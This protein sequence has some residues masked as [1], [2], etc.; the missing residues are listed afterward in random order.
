M[1]LA[2][3]GSVVQ[4]TLVLWLLGILMLL[5]LVGN[6]EQQ[7]TLAH[8]TFPLLDNRFR[9]DHGIDEVTLVVYR[10]SGSAPI[11]LVRPDGS[12]LYAHRHPDNTKWLVTNDFDL[13]TIKTPVPGPW[14]IVGSLDKRNKMRI[15]SNMQLAVDPFPT[16]IFQGERL[17]VTARLMNH[18][19]RLAVDAFY[20][21]TKLSLI[22]STRGINISVDDILSAGKKL[23]EFR[24]DGTGLDEVPRDGVFT[25]ALSFDVIPGNFRLF[26]IVHNDTFERMNVQDVT[27]VPRPVKA[28]VNEDAQEHPTSLHYQ[29]DT[30]LLE[31]DSIAANLEL[32]GSNGSVKRYT[33]EQLTN[34]VLDFDLSNITNIDDYNMQG[35]GYA[36]TRMGREI[37][38]SLPLLRFHIVSAKTPSTT[39]VSPAVADTESSAADTPAIVENTMPLSTG[40]SWWW[41]VAIVAVGVIVIALVAWLLWRRIAARKK[42]GQ[43]EE[44]AGKDA[45]ESDDVD[46]TRPEDD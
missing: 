6:A 42:T 36:T 17:K 45:V 29:F 4:K 3:G 31:T 22:L 2:D 10:K 15:V 43:Q 46:L 20:Q 28:E 26:T 25:G 7:E 35:T 34:G 38:F 27:I 41:W 13:I 5:P 19:N 44:P 33:E 11:I 16:E 8:S 1:V 21:S 30:Q 40:L 12:K 14:Q 24:D 32:Y 9:L 18:D 39:E 37:V 23:G